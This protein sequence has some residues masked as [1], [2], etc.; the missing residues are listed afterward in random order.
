LPLPDALRR[1]AVR[2]EEK[3]AV[4]SPDRALAFGELVR[5][6]DGLARRLG[7]L[8]VAPGERV[9][10]FTDHAPEA[11]AALF[12][13]W[14]AG[15][16]AVPVNGRAGP[17]ALAEILADCAPAATLLCGRFCDEPAERA[18]AGHGPA[19]ILRLPPGAALPDASPAGTDAALP[20]IRD[21]DLAAIVYTSGSTG[22]PKGVC[23][24]HG[25][26]LASVAAI[27]EHVPETPDDSY[28]M[29]VPLHYVHGLMQLVVHALAGATVDFAGDFVFP[30]EVVRMLAERRCV[31]TS[32]TPWHVSMLIERGGLLEADLPAW[33]RVGI[34]GGR[35]PA[36][37]IEAIARAR[38][39]VE[40]LIAYG[41]TECAPRATALSP[42]RVLAKPDS[43]GS[44]IPGVRVHVLDE[45]GGA[46]PQGRIGAVL[47][48]GPNVMAGYWGRPEDTAR[49]ID[50]QGRLRTGDLGWLDEDGDLHLVGRVDDMIKSAGERIFPAEIERVL[51][52]ASGVAEVCVL[53]VPDELLGQRIEAHLALA[54]GAADDG[55]DLGERLRRH[56]LAELPLPRVPQAFHAWPALPRL[57]NG[58]LDRV[59]LSRG[60]A[61]SSRT[62]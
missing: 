34:V 28:L 57:A 60:R 54:P 47:V 53:G 50:A 30:V 5:A 25:N 48:E 27:I 12:G 58:K 1:V 36:E 33:R 8:G 61:A 7:S 14:A 24:S 51:R 26:M 32:G 49:V 43:V 52:A 46:L 59:R 16:V 10:V 2:W 29:L 35:M 22:A 23:L 17:Q 18:A 20:A 4:R 11:A 55:A 56:C 31:E 21:T 62:G 9:A 37:Q 15:A 6:G 44:P 13:V 40:I 41:Q 39:A 3:P 38:P 19:C 45:T 42:A